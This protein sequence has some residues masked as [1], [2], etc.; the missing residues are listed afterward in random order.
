MVMCCCGACDFC[1]DGFDREPSATVGGGWR[2]AIGDWEIIETTGVTGGAVTNTEAPAV[3]TMDAPCN[4]SA[5]PMSL[6]I[7]VEGIP[8]Y[9]AASSRVVIDWIPSA[10]EL[11]SRHRL[12]LGY[13]PTPSTGDPPI[14]IRGGVYLEVA[15]TEDG[16]LTMRLGSGNEVAW[17]WLTDELPIGNA[18]DLAHNDGGT[19]LGKSAFEVGEQSCQLSLCWEPISGYGMRDLAFVRGSVLTPTGT[20]Y[21]LEGVSADQ[22]G[23]H[24]I[25]Q[26]ITGFARWDNMSWQAT[27]PD[28]EECPTCG[29]CTYAKDTTS[30]IDDTLAAYVTSGTVVRNASTGKI[31]VT[32]GGAAWRAQIP[33]QNHFMLTY[34]GDW[35]G[36]SPSITVT[37]GAVVVQIS[38]AISV[39]SV[40][41]ITNGTTHSSF[42]VPLSTSFLQICFGHTQVTIHVGATTVQY[43]TAENEGYVGIELQ[44]GDTPVTFSGLTVL[45]TRM[46]DVIKL[47][48]SPC[49]GPIPPCE[50]CPEV[51]AAYALIDAAVLTEFSD[52]DPGYPP[53][54]LADKACF[55]VPTLAVGERG[56]LDGVLDSR[57]RFMYEDIC[58]NGVY[59]IRVQVYCNMQNDGIPEMGVPATHW[60][61]TA[62]IVIAWYGVT[63]LALVR[64]ESE[65]YS[66]PVT[67]PLPEITLTAEAG[68][69]L[70]QESMVWA[71]G[72]VA[73]ASHVNYTFP[74]TIKITFVL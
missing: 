15:Y 53:G 44:A 52:F 73:P 28:A 43:T 47:N 19:Y 31:E 74:E 26:A 59:D 54:A 55:V 56:I 61:F 65:H 5:P 51:P 12:G 10:A 23:R 21:T 48:C 7:D 37:D 63:N 39:Q 11:P 33:A 68:S 58:G 27:A 67:C 34:E 4:L 30:A 8:T 57:C 70:T 62:T 9:F 14:P 1:A 66:Y 29:D 35:A 13:I 45:S 46:K 42:T 40:T 71:Q 24:P 17:T 60:W 22:D 32:S 41:V 6:L 18:K 69:D 2:E 16:I 36:A 3:L 64:Y 50:L 25:L 72:T 49:L 20:L 38:K